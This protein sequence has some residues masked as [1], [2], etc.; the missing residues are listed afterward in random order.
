MSIRLLMNLDLTYLFTVY[1][2]EEYQSN[3]GAPV[4]RQVPNIYADEYERLTHI[5]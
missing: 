3:P 1:L 4:T 2:V 5:E